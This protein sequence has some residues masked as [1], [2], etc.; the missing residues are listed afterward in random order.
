V[1][2]AGDS[3]KLA[4]YA[5]TRGREETYRFSQAVI[6]ACDRGSPPHCYDAGDFWVSESVED[7][8]T[9]EQLCRGCPVL[10]Y[11]HAAATARRERFGVWAGVDRS[12]G[13]KRRQPS[14]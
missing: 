7:R 12:P 4:T 1:V 11:C 2:Y 14:L 5:L 9:A 10:K 6:E 3:P 8:R 13:K